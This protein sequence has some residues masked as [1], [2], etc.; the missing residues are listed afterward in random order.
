MRHSPAFQQAVSVF[1]LFLAG[2]FAA[3]FGAT[4]AS[5]TRMH[6]HYAP[7]V[8][9]SKDDVATYDDP[10]VR[11]VSLDALGHENGSVVAMD[12]TTGRI[13]T[14]INQ[15]MA[16]S[17][18]FEPCS[19]IKP[20]IAI[21]GLEEGVITRDTMIRVA[22]R[23]YMDL[24]EALAHS[25]NEFFQT[26]GTELGFDRVIKYDRL[27]GLGQRVGYAIPEEQPGA[28]PLAPPAYGG[29]ARMSSFGSG[30]RITPFQ[31]AS[32]VGMLANGGTQY[33][34]QYPR[35]ALERE[36]FEPRVRQQ[37][38]IA[39]V[40]PD[41]R[42]GMLAAVL[43]GSARRSYDPDGEQ[44]LGKTGTCNDEEMG[45][46]LG[47]FASYA[48]Q[49]HPKIV[50]VVLLHGG[51]RKISGPHASEIAGR[52]YR[53]LYERNYFADDDST[54][55]S[56]YLS[57]YSPSSQQSAAASGAIAPSSLGNYSRFAPAAS[58]SSSH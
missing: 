27:L 35:T 45:G 51:S 10:V 15:K 3:A 56:Q 39:P 31:L 53:G 23:R 9:P 32:L 21:A 25:N 57:Q 8:N 18:G 12:P 50:I 42:E 49:A 38:D 55:P 7:P 17:S 28:L 6:R 20:F 24:T 26:V 1:C 37:F 52:I 30:V 48:D 54:N 2:A 44:D 58:F 19:T 13:L 14:I 40:L 29:T 34:L 46:R 16:F 4:P 5:R 47:W 11:D 43:Y 33:Y 22:S 41:L 36:N